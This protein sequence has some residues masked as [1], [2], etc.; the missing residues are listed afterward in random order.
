MAKIIIKGGGRIAQQF[1]LFLKKSETETVLI[2]N[3]NNDISFE[4]WITL[5]L[6]TSKDLPPETKTQFLTNDY[7]LPLPIDKNILTKKLTWSKNNNSEKE[8]LEK[9]SNTSQ[10]LPDILYYLF[11]NNISY[12]WVSS[13][14]IKSAS[15]NKLSTYL[16]K[17][18][19]LDNTEYD[20]ALIF[21]NEYKYKELIYHKKY[22]FKYQLPLNLATE[23]FFQSTDKNY[24]GIFINNKNELE[25]YISKEINP[26]EIFHFISD[27]EVI[28]NKPIEVS[29]KSNIKKIGKNSYRISLSNNL[30]EN[31]KTMLKTCKIVCKKV[32]NGRKK[33]CLQTCIK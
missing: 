22:K 28:L 29:T 2:N 27:G 31:R 16:L 32:N 8:I 23:G 15:N 7:I 26:E 21:E 18:P 19:T 6:I 14:E 30:E 11:N 1:S 17:N 5:P 9:L 20:L 4:N 25:I 13:T 3:N 33:E 24:W 10:S 12:N